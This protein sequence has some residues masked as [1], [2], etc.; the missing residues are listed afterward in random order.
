MN[1]KMPTKR[2]L[3]AIELFGSC[4]AAAVFHGSTLFRSLN[5]TSRPFSILI[6]LLTWGTVVVS[7]FFVTPKSK[8]NVANSL[9]TAATSVAVYFMLSFRDIY[10]VRMVIARFAIL[11][12]IALYSA[13]V[14]YLG[15]PVLKSRNRAKQI[16]VFLLGFANHC[17]MIVGVVLTVV[18]LLSLIVA[19][20][21]GVPVSPEQKC[22]N[23]DTS[24]VTLQ[25][26][27]ETVKLLHEELWIGLSVQER[28]DVLQTVANIEASHLGLPHELKVISV[29]TDE[30]TLGYYAD[31]T[32]TIAINACVL[33]SSDAQDVL[34]VLAHEA[35]HAY[36]Y[37]LADLYRGA[38]DKLR[39][40]RLL[41]RAKVYCEELETYIDG[42]VDPVGYMFQ[43]VELDCDAYAAAA[44]DDYF[45]VIEEYMEM[46]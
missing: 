6:F 23:P 26:N 15:V 20:F 29:S 46:P 8:R 39:N 14:L 16:K 12:G 2:T 4:L 17:R 38:D 28:I 7:G 24:K 36:E 10:P 18:Y 43:S 3:F 11:G 21:C 30:K 41:Q 22:V 33:Q 40:L 31:Q 35:Y 34:E 32:H 42:E 27:L 45:T 25:D 9:I 37:R 19:I 1:K 44:V 5:G 13:L